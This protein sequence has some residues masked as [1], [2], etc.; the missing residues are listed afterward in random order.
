MPGAFLGVRELPGDGGQIQSIRQILVDIEE[1]YVVDALLGHGRSQ[2]G[3]DASDG[4]KEPF[5]SCSGKRDCEIDPLQFKLST[6]LNNGGSQRC[7]AEHV[8]QGDLG[9][10]VRAAVQK[11]WQHT[12]LP[13]TLPHVNVLAIQVVNFRRD[14]TGFEFRITKDDTQRS[15]MMLLYCRKQDIY[16]FFPFP[17]FFRDLILSLATNG[18]GQGPRDPPR[19]A[20]VR[21]Y[22]IWNM[23]H[24]TKTFD[25]QSSFV[26]FNTLSQVQGTHAT[27]PHR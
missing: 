18:G 2:V 14:C 23:V 26:A 27:L 7:S 5:P 25:M 16:T 8:C 4:R 22:R 24:N 9:G 11:I 12:E 21:I 6:S 15:Q 13:F 10:N 20:T 19:S 3:F 17:F 1:H